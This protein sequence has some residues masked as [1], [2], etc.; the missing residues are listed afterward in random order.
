MKL[1][2]GIF[3]GALFSS[4]I[5]YYINKKNEDKRKAL[6]ASV[7]SAQPVNLNM[8]EP[9]DEDPEPVLLVENPFTI[10]IGSNENFYYYNG[11]N[12]NGLQKST[13]AQLK[14]QIASKKEKTNPKKLMFIIK[15][16][17]DAGFKSVIDVLDELTIAGIPVGHYAEVDV[18]ENEKDCIKN[19]KKK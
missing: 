2:I 14:V 8:T 12:C 18:S 4:G 19:Y 1:I 13:L 3:I 9:K 11:K 7:N 17:Q 6:I 16:L 10:L 15:S 5:F